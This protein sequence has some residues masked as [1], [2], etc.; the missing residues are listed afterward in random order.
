MKLDLSKPI[1]RKELLIYAILMGVL[2]GFE[3]LIVTYIHQWWGL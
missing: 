1:T 3:P 2:R